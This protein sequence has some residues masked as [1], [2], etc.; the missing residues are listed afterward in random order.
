[1]NPHRGPQD[2]GSTHEKRMFRIGFG[3]DV[4][5]LVEGRPLILG[6]IAIPSSVG[7]DGHSDGDA[8]LHAVT[9]ALLGS[10]ALGDIG[11][12]FPDNDERFRNADSSLFV[13]SA[14]K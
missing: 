11:T 3:T 2:R 6:G 14:L 8:L 12:H 4:H 9:D 5:R 1:D 10:L 7:P 13:T